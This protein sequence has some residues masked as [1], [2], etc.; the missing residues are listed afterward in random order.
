MLQ[1]SLAKPES[2]PDPVLL[3]Q[4]ARGARA[5]HSEHVVVDHLSQIQA[6][7]IHTRAHTYTIPACAFG[8]A[9]KPLSPRSL[10]LNKV[11]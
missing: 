9:H 4:F 7:R 8:L 6:A 10:C 2:K 3:D 11:A 5:E 1:N